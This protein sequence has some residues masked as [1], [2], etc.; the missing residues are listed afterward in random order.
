MWPDTAA[1]HGGARSA[2]RR[3][4]SLLPLPSSSLLPLR[5]MGPAAHLTCQVGLIR[6]VRLPPPTP[7]PT[8]TT[9]LHPRGGQPAAA[10][11]ATAAADPDAPPLGACPLRA[12]GL[13]P[14]AG[15]APHCGVQSRRK[16]NKEINR[17]DPEGVTRVWCWRCLRVAARPAGASLHGVA[18]SG[19]GDTAAEASPA[20]RELQQA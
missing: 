6:Q 18:N 4:M 11:A 8:N 14:L 13:D 19:T 15:A 20:A 17:V 2:R 1:G 3:E 12:A 10:E 5:Q 9:T 7:L 16:K